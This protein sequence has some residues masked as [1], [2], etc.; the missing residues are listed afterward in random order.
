MS[1]LKFLRNYNN[2]FN[3]IVKVEQLASI[4]NEYVDLKAN[5]NPNDDVTTSHV[6]PKWTANWMPDYMLKINETTQEIESRWFVTETVRLR[7]QQY[8]FDLKRDL[9]A[10][11]HDNIITAPMLIKRAMIN[12]V[13]NPLLYNNEGFSFNQIK[14]SETLLKDGSQSA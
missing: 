5:F 8:R 13:N 7:G 2:L 4:N 11:Y 1:Y 10:D 12:D 3:R 9:L 14:T 6:S